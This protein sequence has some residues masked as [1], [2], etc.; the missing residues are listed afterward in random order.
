TGRA[1]IALRTGRAGI[2]LRTG[3][4]GIAL[5]TGRA[6]IALRTGRAGLSLRAGRA[7]RAGRTRCC[8]RARARGPVDLL[9]VRL[10]GERRVAVVH[11]GGVPVPAEVVVAPTRLWRVHL[12]EPDASAILVP[13]SVEAD[14]R[15]EARPRRQGNEGARVRP[16]RRR[17]IRQRARGDE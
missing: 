16:V 7:G 14:A 10:A 9:L 1:G 3:R 6:G 4:A 17:R 12:D 8:G 2:A 15:H 11:R 13:A 5:R